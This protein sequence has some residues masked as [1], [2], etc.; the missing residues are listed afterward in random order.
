MD[1]A[2]H[3][4]TLDGGVEGPRTDETLNATNANPGPRQ[5]SPLQQQVAVIGS[6]LAGLVTAY[7]LTVNGFAVD[8]YER[9]TGLGMA[10]A[11]VVMPKQDGTKF[12]MDVPMRSFFPEN[13]SHLVSLYKYFNIDYHTSENSTSY[14]DYPPTSESQ[15]QSIP[16][17]TLY[18]SFSCYKIPFTSASISLPNLPPFFD[19]FS[20]IHFWSAL[21]YLLHSMR[22]VYGYIKFLITI[23]I[24][25]AQ[26]KLVVDGPLKNLTL[27]DF[28]IKYGIGKEFVEGTFEPL[29]CGLCTCSTEVLR[30][31]PAVVILDWVARSMPFGKMSFVTNGVQTICAELAKPINNLFL[32]TTIQSVHTLSHERTDP[33]VSEDAFSDVVVETTDGRRQT[34]QHVIFAT[35]ANQAARIIRASKS[36]EEDHEAKSQVEILDR[37]TYADTVV[38][39]HTDGQLMPKDKSKWRCLNFFKPTSYDPATMPATTANPSMV[40]PFEPQATSACTHWFNISHP[41]LSPHGK[42]QYFQTTNPHALPDPTLTLSTAYFERAVVTQKSLTALTHLE[43]LQGR[44]RRWFVGSYAWESIPL[45]EGCVASATNIVRQIKGRHHEKTIVPWQDLMANTGQVGILNREILLVL[46]VTLAIFWAYLFT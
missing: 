43:A 4:S 17:S 44:G 33:S 28:W 39:C 15:P 3:T 35:Q 40:L 42:I 23:K 27:E 30:E 16:P 8:L 29:F 26:G 13:Y 11:S 1:A 25:A 9:N 46:S 41:A 12:I 36:F 19:F 18:F 21:S 20:G 14:S 45:L 37:F 31:F 10:A 22:V 38:V 32:N 7:L 34:Y 6:G 24:L 2:R 5:D